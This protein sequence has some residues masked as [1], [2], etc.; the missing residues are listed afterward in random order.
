M[1]GPLDLKKQ[2]SSILVYFNGTSIWKPLHERFFNFQ[3]STLHKLFCVLLSRLHNQ[4]LNR[5]QFAR[6]GGI[7]AVLEAIWAWLGGSIPLPLHKQRGNQNIPES[8]SYYSGLRPLLWISDFVEW[9]HTRTGRPPK[10][11]YT[12]NQTLNPKPQNPKIKP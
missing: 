1:E 9:L 5:F 6:T 12:L 11:P 8:D 7:H 3:P 2:D 4:F 10:T